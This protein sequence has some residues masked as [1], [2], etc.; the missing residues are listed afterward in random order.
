MTQGMKK[1]PKA[2]YSYMNSKRKIR[3][4]VVS[5]KGKTGHLAKTPKDTANILA[6]FFE[7]TFVDPKISLDIS[8]QYAQDV[9]NT[10]KLEPVS[11]EEVGKL[12]KKAVLL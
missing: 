2:F 9:L 1:N 5:V 10:T 6:E 3:Q 8:D 12:L 11:L 4:T 7:S